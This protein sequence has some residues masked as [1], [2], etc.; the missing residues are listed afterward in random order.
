[1]KSRVYVGSTVIQLPIYYLLMI[2]VLD[3]MLQ[4]DQGVGNLL[5]WSFGEFDEA[6]K[7]ELYA[8]FWNEVIARAE[9]DD[10]SGK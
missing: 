2:C 7:K 10:L 5:D 9:D 8:A 6:S 3:N 4:P 1:M